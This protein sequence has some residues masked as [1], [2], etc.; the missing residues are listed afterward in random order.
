MAARNLTVTDIEGALR[1]E[2]VELGAGMIE[3]KDR[4]FTMRTIRTYQTPK[5]FAQLVIARGAGN[6]L[7]RLGELATVELG[8]V[9]V[10]SVNRI[11]EKKPGPCPSS[12]LASSNSLGRRL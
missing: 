5:D 2:N 3:S 10:H 12:D 4:N 9:D 6:Y 11:D 7:I 1:R 8:P